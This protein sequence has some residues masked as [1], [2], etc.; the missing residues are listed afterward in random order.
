MPFEGGYSL[1]LKLAWANGAV[2]SDL[3]HAIFERKLVGSNPAGRHGRS[4]MDTAWVDPKLHGIEYLRDKV[5]DGSLVTRVGKWCNHIAADQVLR[6]CPD[7]LRSGYQSALFQIDGMRECPIHGEPLQSVCMQCGTKTPRYALT[8]A[9]FSTPFFCETCSSPLAGEFDPQRWDD[10]SFR[11]DVQTALAPFARWLDNLSA[12][13]LSWKNWDEWHFPLRWHC[14]E[15]ERRVATLQTLLSALPPDSRLK[16]LEDQRM[17]PRLFLG[18]IISEN[19]TDDADTGMR[20]GSSRKDRI[21]IYKSIRRHVVHK[22]SGC[23]STR[24]AIRPLAEIIDQMHMDGAIHLSLSA[25][26]R[27]QAL[28]LWRLHFEE[29]QRDPYLLVFRPAV[30]RW[31]GDIT[32][33]TSGWAGYVLAS[34]HAAVSAFDAWR[35]QATRIPDANV[36]G[37][38]QPRARALYAQYAPLLNPLQLPSFPAV[39]LLTFTDVI[40][41]PRLLVVGPG[42]PTPRVKLESDR[43]PLWCGCRFRAFR[44]SPDEQ[45]AE[46]LNVDSGQLPSQAIGACPV[47]LAYVAPLGQLKLPPQL[48]GSQDEA[49]RVARKCHLS[50]KNDLQAVEEW[51]NGFESAKTRYA[52]RIQ[53]EKALTWSVAQRHKPLSTLSVQDTAAFLAFLRDPVP[54]EVWLPSRTSKATKRWTPFRKVASR[55]SSD[56]TL[57]ILALLFEHWCDQGYVATN[58]CR[59]RVRPI[60]SEPRQSSEKVYAPREA[61]LTAVEWA[62]LWKAAQSQY[63]NEASS[64]LAFAYFAGLLPNEIAAIQISAFSRIELESEEDSIWSVTIG[65]RPLQ[66]QE[67]F[68]LPVVVQ[69]VGPFFPR[70]SNE[71]KSFTAEKG[72]VYLMDLINQSGYRRRGSTTRG[73][74]ASSLSS[75]IGCA[76]ADAVSLAEAAGDELAAVRL[77]EASLLWVSLAFEQHL[78]QGGIANV[79]VWR[80]IAACDSFQQSCGSTYRIELALTRWLFGKPLISC[81]R[82]MKVRSDYI[83]SATDFRPCSAQK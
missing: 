25:C 75:K 40:K 6:Y 2:A 5:V 34:F 12:S 57:A 62:Y 77:K 67:V 79:N 83:V 49:A 56:Y 38:D 55:R 47:T 70:D 17:G 82:F 8:E 61:M 68:L 26:P 24:A 21:A 64:I 28:A 51:L 66:R 27:A 16:G 44:S 71:F 20:L 18:S 37:T 58:P 54:H 80:V 78:D 32:I 4:L 74:T 50:A 15:T 31:P 72:E 46:V 48:D 7:C 69:L 33:D 81:S 11:D 22:L 76:L 45:T 30:L 9:G 19:S 60:G 36:Y 23:G 10:R 42:E 41:R 53:I 52:Y 59:K 1:L 14:S 73:P 63:S 29:V 3:C 43:P 39:S 13:S 65:T 35:T